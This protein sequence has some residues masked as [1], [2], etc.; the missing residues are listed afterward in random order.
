MNITSA[1]KLLSHWKRQGLVV[2]EGNA[3]RVLFAFEAK[4][5][6]RLPPDMRR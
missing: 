3:E 4:N 5:S 2:A 6:V 1:E